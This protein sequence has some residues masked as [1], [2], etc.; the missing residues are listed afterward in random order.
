MTQTAD[1]SSITTGRHLDR[2][3]GPS[4]TSGIVLMVALLLMLGLLA[5]LM[6]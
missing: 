1:R 5:L 3:A 2:T 6:T 4:E